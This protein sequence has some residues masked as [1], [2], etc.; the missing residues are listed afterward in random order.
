MIL[1]TGASGFIGKHLL[2]GLIEKYGRNNVLAL[3]SR[4]I[5]ECPYLLHN[6]YVFSSDLF[7]ENNYSQS[8]DTIIHAGAFIPKSSMDG[9]N[10]KLCNQSVFNTQCLL[11]A[12]LPSLQRFIY[13]SS[14]DVYGKT[15]VISEDTIVD[16]VS[17][18][19]QSKW[20][21]EKMIDAWA[22]TEGKM[23]QV[24]RIGHVYGPGEESYQKIIPVTMKKIIANDPVE[25]WGD[26]NELRAFIYIN[27]VV[28]TI[29]G[30]L[31]FNQTIGPLNLVSSN[32]ISIKDLI[33]KIIAISGEKANVQTISASGKARDLVFD[34]SKVKQYLGLKE[35]SLDLGLTTEWK[36]MQSLAS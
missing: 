28:K 35:T 22:Y 32:S 20:Y 2:K 27:D 36:Y 4:P 19:G 9:N 17:L 30:C 3:T 33:N 14:V 31:N 34:N 5:E 6:N 12:K 1:L 29:I 8:I 10:W 25:I 15:D 13:L 26:G 11:D 23:N 24:L 16:P 18:Y 7:S 21:T